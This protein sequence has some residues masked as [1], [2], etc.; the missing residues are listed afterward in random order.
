[1]FQ[2]TTKAVDL[3]D[4]DQIELAAVG[5]SHEAV[6]LRSPLAGTRDTFIDVLTDDLPPTM[7]TILAQLRQLHFWI[8]VV[9][10]RNSGVQSDPHASPNTTP[11]EK[12]G[13]SGGAGK[14]I[15]SECTR[16]ASQL[17]TALHMTHFRS[18]GRAMKTLPTLSIIG[19]PSS[20]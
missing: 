17:N 5:I 14:Q 15:S 3:P 4:G 20:R 6:E 9:H 1:M 13:H 12:G 18:G 10:S 8:L 19:L 7:G 11:Y 2:R 16:L